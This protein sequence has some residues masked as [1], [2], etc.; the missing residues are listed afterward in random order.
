MKYR[1]YKETSII[2]IVYIQ[3][4]FSF[5][6]KKKINFNTEYKIYKNTLFLFNYKVTF[7][8]IFIIEYKYILSTIKVKKNLHYLITKVNN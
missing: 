1:M 3:A 8:N 2:F 5:F 4:Y 6:F 7:N